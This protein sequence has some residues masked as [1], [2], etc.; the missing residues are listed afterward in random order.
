MAR[1]H[2]QRMLRQQKQ[3]EAASAAEVRALEK[4]GK[5]FGMQTGLVQELGVANEQLANRWDS[6]LDFLEKVAEAEK[7]DVQKG[8]RPPRQM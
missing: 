4:K 8:I 7:R 5:R 2:E 1:Q 3:A 6:R